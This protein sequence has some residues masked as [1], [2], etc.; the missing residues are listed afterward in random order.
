[1]AFLSPTVATLMWLLIFFTGRWI[2]D[3]VGGI[4]TA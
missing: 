1:V 3:R 2:E 4:K